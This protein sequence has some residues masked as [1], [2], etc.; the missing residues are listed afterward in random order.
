MKTR[1]LFLVL[2]LVCI[3]SC[4]YLLTR[5]SS[6]F[7]KDIVTTVSDTQILTGTTIT[8]SQIVSTKKENTVTTTGPVVTTQP[9][10]ISDC[11][12]DNPYEGWIYSTA[13]VL[14]VYKAPDDKSEVTGKIYNQNIV[15]AIGET[16]YYNIISYNDSI[17][18][19][20]KEDF[21]IKGRRKNTILQKMDNVYFSD[22]S[23]D[24]LALIGSSTTTSPSFSA[25][26][27]NNLKVSAKATSIV[28]RA[29]CVFSFN[30]T[31][32]PRTTNSGYLTASTLDSSGNK[33]SG[34]GG[35]VCQTA[36]TI[37]VAI[38]DAISNGFPL[39]DIESNLHSAPVSYLSN[40]DYEAMVNW[41]WSDFRFKN[42]SNSDI[43]L[44]VSA[45][46]STVNV[47]IYEIQ[48]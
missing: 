21:G 17:G 48:L 20:K 40:R 44:E 7:V 14:K 29:G 46:D 37:H 18:F 10:N 25:N 27:N 30:Q 42:N 13:G 12:Y 8:K 43:V 28:V 38:L 1:Y 31:T 16:N 26:R 22:I 47:S 15:S 33:S 45:K 4:F 11:L 6:F 39:E 9:F 23:K 35:G 3:I 24:N 41:G 5:G 36:S 32:G 34:V 19:I 2:I